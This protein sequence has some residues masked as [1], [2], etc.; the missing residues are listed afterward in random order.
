MHTSRT[1][2]RLLVMVFVLGI[3]LLTG[4]TKTEVPAISRVTVVE[5]AP[6]HV[7][8]K[9]EI[10]GEG[11]TDCGICYST[12]N[13]SPSPENTGVQVMNGSLN[14][15]SFLCQVTL[16][17]GQ[18]WYIAVWATNEAATITS[19][20]YRITTSLLSPSADDNPLPQP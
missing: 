3:G 9:A 10:R 7:E 11:I 1:G 15:H 18:E 12:N 14:G 20:A 2:F 19:T 8:V 4:C 5:G 17:A 13:P 16:G 6:G